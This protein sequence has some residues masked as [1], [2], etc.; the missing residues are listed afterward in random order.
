MASS[1]SARTAPPPDSLDLDAVEDYGGIVGAVLYI[2]LDKLLGRRRRDDRHR[3][4]PR[5][6]ASSSSTGASLG[7]ALRHSARAGGHLARHTARAARRSVERVQGVPDSFTARRSRRIGLPS[8][9][10]EAYGDVLGPSHDQSTGAVPLLLDQLVPEDDAA[11]V[12]EPSLEPPS[13]EDNP[14]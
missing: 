11:E 7:A 8:T 6:Q 1:A 4:R 14:R 2:V 9:A 10:C 5:R 12:D 3:A 13:T